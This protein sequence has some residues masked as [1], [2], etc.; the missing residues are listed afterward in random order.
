MAGCSI[1]V[2]SVVFVSSGVSDVPVN[3]GATFDSVPGLVH[4]Y[5]WLQRLGILCCFCKQWQNVM[6]TDK[7]N[8]TFVSYK[9]IMDWCS[10]LTLSVLSSE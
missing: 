2:Y 6:N 5:G 4:L 7:E 1:L 9:I 8:Y 3:L 10:C